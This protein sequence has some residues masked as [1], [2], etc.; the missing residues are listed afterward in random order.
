MRRPRDVVFSGGSGSSDSITL[1]R[2]APT[3]LRLGALFYTALRKAAR[4]LLFSVLRDFCKVAASRCCF[5]RAR[6][7]TRY[8]ALALRSSTTRALAILR[9]FFASSTI[10]FLYSIAAA[11]RL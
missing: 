11:L 6:A 9:S 7:A 3:T 5:L 10:F 1:L 2:A 4:L 8:A